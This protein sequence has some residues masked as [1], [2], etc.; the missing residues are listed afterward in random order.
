MR[1][2]YLLMGALVVSFGCSS[3]NNDSTGK[4]SN[5]QNGT[6]GDGNASVPIPPDGGAPPSD[7][8]QIAGGETGIGFDDLMYSKKLHRMLVP[9]GWTGTVNLIDPDTLA[10]TTISGF[11]ADPSW[12]SGD[13]RGV[14][15]MDE[16]NGLVFVGDRSSSE[17]GIVDPATNQIVRKVPLLGYPD[18]VRYVKATDEIWVTEISQIEILKGA[19]E[20]MPVSDGTIDVGG[21]PEALA[22]DQ[23]RGIAFSMH[24]LAGEVVAIDVNTRQQ[25]G[26]WPTGCGSSHGL[27]AIDE[28]NGFVFPGCLE[29]ARAAVLDIDNGGAQLDEYDMNSGGSTLVAF[30]SKLRHFYLRGDPGLPLG[31]LGVSATGTLTHFNTFDSVQKA[32]CLA[33]DDVGGFWTCDWSAGTIVRY[34]DPYP[35]SK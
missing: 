33:S 32:H 10:V 5:G 25:I 23:T 31:V 22:I 17:L 18:Y 2:S 19:N 6:G 4:D 29:K 27:V 13:T 28:T 9:G 16:G 20:G 24:L 34:K 14:G 3:S 7:R 8:I 35:A 11:T 30:S 1:V 12:D 21:V 15:S 26:V